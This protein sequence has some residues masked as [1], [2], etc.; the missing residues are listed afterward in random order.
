V[1]GSWQDDSIKGDGN[2]NR[3][4]GHLGGDTI[5]GRA[6]DDVLVGGMGADT[7]DGGPGKDTF[8]YN[9][10]FESTSAVF[11]NDQNVSGAVYGWT[12]GFDTIK[13]FESGIDKIDLS[14]ISDHLHFAS[15]ASDQS[16]GAIRITDTSVT[17][18]TGIAGDP[19]G[20]HALDFLI[21]VN[22]VHA[23]DLLL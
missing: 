7:L 23:G 11:A 3:L 10:F 13:N 21:H 4:D 8:V 17:V 9:S 18:A 5:Y 12:Y 6:G 14:A 2:S 1:I 20:Y 16:E 15:S 19:H 22:G